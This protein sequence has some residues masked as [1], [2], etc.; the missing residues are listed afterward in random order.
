MFLFGRL[1]AHAGPTTGSLSRDLGR[2]RSASFDVHTAIREIGGS[3]DC[4]SEIF[5][6]LANS[7]CLQQR[8]G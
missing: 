5:G 6:P 7:G 8:T 3:E 1:R 2:G 4:P